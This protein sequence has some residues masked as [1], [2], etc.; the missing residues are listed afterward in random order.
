[1]GSSQLKE[2]KEE[3]GEEGIKEKRKRKEKREKHGVVISSRAAYKL[4]RKT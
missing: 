1:M 4:A 2:E 3:R